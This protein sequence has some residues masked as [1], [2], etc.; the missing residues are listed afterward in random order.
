MLDYLGGPHRPSQMSLSE[1]GRGRVDTHKGEREVIEGAKGDCK[2]TAEKSE[3]GRECQH[4]LKL[5]E[6]GNRIFPRASGGSAA[7]STP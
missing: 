3:Q 5:K 1:R 6:P 4:L 7:F 2:G